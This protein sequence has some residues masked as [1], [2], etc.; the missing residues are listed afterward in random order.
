MFTLWIA[1]AENGT[2]Q[3]DTCPSTP[4]VLNTCGDL[5]GEIT[6]HEVTLQEISREQLF[7]VA[8]TT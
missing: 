2:I 1:E 5:E 3:F 6:V 8:D 7:V 4:D